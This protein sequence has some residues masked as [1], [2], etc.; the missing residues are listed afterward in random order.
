MNNKIKEAVKTAQLEENK[1]FTDDIIYKESNYLN[2][3]A[4]NINAENAPDAQ[5]EEQRSNKSCLH[6]HPSSILGWGAPS[7]LSVTQEQLLGGKL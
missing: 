6:G 7:A 1:V 5:L 3:C 4:N 2:F